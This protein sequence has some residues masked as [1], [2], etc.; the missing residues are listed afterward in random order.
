[1]H[2]ICRSGRA[3]ILAVTIGQGE[4]GGGPRQIFLSAQNLQ[5]PIAL[6]RPHLPS[7][8]AANSRG[9]SCHDAKRRGRGREWEGVLEIGKGE[10]KNSF[11]FALSEGRT[12]AGRVYDFYTYSDNPPPSEADLALEGI[13]FRLSDICASTAAHA[14]LFFLR[15]GFG[16]GDDSL[17]EERYFSSSATPISGCPKTPP[18]QNPFCQNPH[19]VSP[20]SLLPP[21]LPL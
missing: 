14:H 17:Q 11:F 18:Q 5:Q 19:S 7:L 8:I 13:R 12:W 4:G 21:V 20:K 2:R 1:M 15:W 9:R 6:F 3:H 16:G 10:A